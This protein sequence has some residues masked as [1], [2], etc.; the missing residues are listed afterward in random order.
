MDDSIVF[1]LPPRKHLNIDVST[2]LPA[3]EFIPMTNAIK[4]LTG[5]SIF[6]FLKNVIQNCT[7]LKIFRGEDFT[8]VSVTATYRSVGIGGWGIVTSMDDSMY[9]LS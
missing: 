6:C 4:G 9:T 3:S 5:V 1:I 8:K 7:T 2:P